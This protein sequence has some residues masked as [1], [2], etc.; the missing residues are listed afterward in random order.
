M[1]Q[2][3]VFA[4]ASAALSLCN[5]YVFQYKNVPPWI[6]PVGWDMKVSVKIIFLNIIVFSRFL[7]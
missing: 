5:E 1:S 4:V 7:C 2:E 6:V 3:L